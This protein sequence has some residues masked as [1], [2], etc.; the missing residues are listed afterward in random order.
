MPLGKAEGKRRGKPA[1]TRAAWR[2]WLET[3]HASTGGGVWLVINRKGS[4]LPHL[5]PGE[6]RRVP[7]P[8]ADVPA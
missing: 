7:L 4:G 3:N 6:A 8:V 2:A 5:P 1:A